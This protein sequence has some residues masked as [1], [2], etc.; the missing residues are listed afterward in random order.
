MK[1]MTVLNNDQ[2]RTKMLSEFF[3]GKKRYTTK[4]FVNKKGPVFSNKK[5]G[6]FNK[7]HHAEKMDDNEL[8]KPQKASIL[9]LK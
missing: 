3:R 6:D 9:I 2:E 7:K 8:N 1:F 4:I 5:G